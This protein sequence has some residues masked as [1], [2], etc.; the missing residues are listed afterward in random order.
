MTEKE[1]LVRITEIINS[2]SGKNL[3]ISLEHDLRDD[4]VLDSLDT[5]VFFMEL[6]SQTG[7]S[8]PDSENLV[9]DGWYK[10]NKLCTEL[11]AI[12]AQNDK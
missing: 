10:I 6:E 11:V 7:L 2:I 8:I 3:K 5:M 12:N 4:D 1:A 9:E